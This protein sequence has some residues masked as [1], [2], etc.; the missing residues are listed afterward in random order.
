M[1]IILKTLSLV[2]LVIS[3]KS[4]ANLKLSL[5]NDGQV[6]Y[7]SEQQNIEFD[8]SSIPDFNLVHVITPEYIYYSIHKSPSQKLVLSPE[9]IFSDSL[10]FTGFKKG[11]YTIGLGNGNNHELE[12]LYVVYSFN[13]DVK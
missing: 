1:N 12:K 10:I 5:D 11:Y 2:A 6:I 4:E 3:C 7:I 9:T 13:L 8:V